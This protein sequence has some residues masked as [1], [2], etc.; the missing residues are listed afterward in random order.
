MQHTLAH[1]RDD[2]GLLKSK[3]YPTCFTKGHTSAD[4]V[5]LKTVATDEQ[6]ILAIK[7][8]KINKKGKKQQRVLVLTNLAVY[9]FK[10][11]LLGSID[12]K[13]YKRRIELMSIESI[14][15]NTSNMNE[16]I[17]K[18]PAEYDYRYESTEVEVIIMS[19]QHAWNELRVGLCSAALSVPMQNKLQVFSLDD[20]HITALLSTKSVSGGGSGSF[21]SNKQRTQPSDSLSSLSSS[22][23]SASVD[24]HK[25]SLASRSRKIID[26]AGPTSGGSTKSER[27][28]RRS[29]V[30]DFITNNNNNNTNTNNIDREH[31]TGRL[32]AA[33]SLRNV[34]ERSRGMSRQ[35]TKSRRMSMRD[36]LLDN[37]VKRIDSGSSSSTNSIHSSSSPRPLNIEGKNIQQHTLTEGSS[38]EERLDSLESL[39]SMFV[40]ER[41]SSTTYNGTV[42]WTPRKRPTS[43]LRDNTQE[44]KTYQEVSNQTKTTARRKSRKAPAVPSMPAMPAMPAM[45]PG[46]GR[47]KS[48]KGIGTGLPPSIAPPT[49]SGTTRP[50]P[51]P[52]TSSSSSSSSSST[53]TTTTSSTSP[54]RKKR[55][56]RSSIID[57]S[58][59]S[60]LNNEEVAK[61][62]LRQ[63]GVVALL[64]MIDAVSE[65]KSVGDDET[66]RSNLL[67]ELRNQEMHDVG[68]TS[69][70]VDTSVAVDATTGLR[71]PT[72]L[73]YL[74]I[75]RLTTT[76]L[77]HAEA[78]PMLIS[79]LK[80][81]VLLVEIFLDSVLSGI[82][83]PLERPR[84]WAIKALWKT[85][86]L[87][88]EAKLIHGAQDVSIEFN[89]GVTEGLAGLCKCFHQTDYQALLQ[90]LLNLI[91]IP[92]DTN[93]S[94]TVEPFGK[95]INA[96]K[97]LPL[98]F[99]LLLLSNNTM[100]KDVLKDVNYL[101]CTS[102]IQNVRAFVSQKNWQDWMLPLLH[103]IPYWDG[104]N[105][106]VKD[107]VKDRAH[108]VHRRATKKEV[109]P[110][111]Q[112]HL[113]SKKTAPAPKNSLP[114]APSSKKN[115]KN[116]QARSSNK[117]NAL[118]GFVKKDL[119]GPDDV[120]KELRALLL[121]VYAMV[122]VFA[123]R[124]SDYSID[125]VLNTG[126][127]R[128][129]RFVGAALTHDVVC[130]TRSILIGLIHKVKTKKNIIR[131]RDDFDSDEWDALFRL[132][133]VV[134]DFLFKK[135]IPRRV[136]L[137]DEHD[138]VNHCTPVELF[139]DRCIEIVI[140]NDPEEEEQNVA[141][142]VKQCPIGGRSMLR[143]L[144]PEVRKEVKREINS[145]N[146]NTISA[147]FLHLNPQTMHCLDLQLVNAVCDMM[148][149]VGYKETTK[150]G[151]RFSIQMQQQ[152]GCTPLF[153][154]SST[155]AYKVE[156]TLTSNDVS[157]MKRSSLDRRT[158]G[159]DIL[160]DFR[161]IQYM[162]RTINSSGDKQHTN[163][164]HDNDDT[165][166][167]EGSGSNTTDVVDIAALFEAYMTKAKKRSKTGLISNA[168]SK[169][170]VV[171]EFRGALTHLKA[172]KMIR[173]QSSLHVEKTEA[174][175]MTRAQKEAIKSAS[176]ISL[177]PAILQI[178]WGGKRREESGGSTS[179]P[180]D[181]VATVEGD[182]EIHR[183]SIQARGSILDELLGLDGMLSI[184]GEH[185]CHKCGL[186]MSGDK[187][188]YAASKYWCLEN[189]QCFQCVK[190]SRVPPYLRYFE[191]DEDIYCSDCYLD[192]SFGANLCG[193]CF[194]PI[195][196]DDEDVRTEG[197]SLM[198]R[199]YHRDCLQCTSCS[200]HLLHGR[201]AGEMVHSVKKKPF[202]G[203]CY[204]EKYRTCPKCHLDPGP[205]ALF[206]CDKNWHPKCFS[207]AECNMTF[208]ALG[209]FFSKDALDGRG[210]LPYCAQHFSQKFS[211]K[212]TS[213][214]QPINSIDEGANSSNGSSATTSP[215]KE[216]GSRFINA[217]S[218]P[219]HIECFQCTVCREQLEG[220][221]F[222]EGG[223]FYCEH[224][225][226]E[227]FG[228]TCFGCQETIRDNCLQASEHTWHIQCFKC[229]SC[230]EQ[231]DPSV[232]F[233]HGQRIFCEACFCKSG[234]AEMC[235][236]CG[237][238]II[239]GGVQIIR[240][241]ETV[242]WHPECA[243]CAQ[244]ERFLTATTAPDLFKVDENK[245]L[246]CTQHWQNKFLDCCD[247]CNLRIEG[248]E[249]LEYPIKD[250][251]GEDKNVRYHY[252][253]VQ[254]VGCDLFLKDRLDAGDYHAQVDQM[255][256]PKDTA[257][258]NTVGT[259]CHDCHWLL[260]CDS[261]S[262]CA[263]YIL[264]GQPKKQ[265]QNGTTWHEGCFAC[266]FCEQ[267]ITGSIHPWKGQEN[268]YCCKEHFIEEFLT[269][270]IVCDEPILDR[271][272]PI[273]GQS[274]H[275]KCI[276]CV[277]CGAAGIDPATQQVMGRKI[278]DPEPEQEPEQELAESNKGSTT[279]ANVES[280]LVCKDHQTPVSLTAEC[281]SKVHQRY[282]CVAR[283]LK[284]TLERKTKHAQLLETT[285]NALNASVQKLAKKA[286]DKQ[287]K[288]MHVEAFYLR[289]AKRVKDEV[290]TQSLVEEEEEV[291]V[292]EEEEVKV[293]EENLPEG[294][295]ICL[296]DGGNTYYHQQL[297]GH[298]QW[299]F[300]GKN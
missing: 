231:L 172:R 76:I 113:S 60:P 201:G 217:N 44:T 156:H 252:E 174:M 52:P 8:I 297:S 213:C 10:Y 275:M 197:V 115:H 23:S 238:H 66:C 134:K 101:L 133:R 93:P 47:R 117:W 193:T 183:N 171:R 289:G 285:G 233:A 198:G 14:H 127:E 232:Y 141:I 184:V 254:C 215:E 244:C 106:T 292:K 81:N 74:K 51:P 29:S 154:G 32:R 210:E 224:D 258:S 105:K 266:I 107:R 268:M 293:E 83:C 53:S 58:P 206:Y 247:A 2:V 45:P 300:P 4:V 187:L 200:N 212:C 80:E 163:I 59:A 131:W 263:E 71:H 255:F 246:Y 9:N 88:R 160:R 18:V 234:H 295:E 230:N 240:S 150:G 158:L 33:S 185:D 209:E 286:T 5:Y 48:T 85:L 162:F 283:D 167:C 91:V 155:K 164:A 16:F 62:L 130:V 135:R 182:T 28:K 146:A 143:P 126:I 142:K 1:P 102:H 298:T 3:Y 55:R 67:M 116:K 144:R 264:D 54:S 63:V 112:R 50:L 89:V 176:S 137:D 253:C 77:Y 179:P 64:Q 208:D 249:F 145:M 159:A 17:L 38:R 190:C 291:K 218:M 140:E 132:V 118:K 192:S 214:A 15:S 188:I 147:I 223:Q 97:I 296:D 86:S 189:L 205:D 82:S 34:L 239:E 277:E 149:V 41:S 70:L 68:R 24:G 204:Q 20:N 186:R 30:S 207:C 226:F 37:T 94:K 237:K 125:R 243:S 161:D 49:S 27:R 194:K 46:M 56:R 100:R 165:T 220:E 40:H 148:N 225:Y 168:F 170:Q 260:H 251:N 290:V 92:T 294:W 280:F 219:F 202:C 151:G 178:G 129:K 287:K 228:E 11:S 139:G 123:F 180:S 136:D 6:L 69:D 267:P 87:Y 272:I 111:P 124:H 271:A 96:P 203:A 65:V 229:Y 152:M 259:Y 196:L 177:P 241:D 166:G 269:S 7:L 22:S 262:W 79:V 276:L 270:C 175:A 120:Q 157:S 169:K 104:G 279:V 248:V 181:T 221:F 25:N 26:G 21:R 72:S 274:Y 108:Q 191:Q 122:H 121:N 19:L 199:I 273:F 288:K 257:G 138:Y 278:S 39:L 103:R 227:A 216:R 282:V 119:N 173:A 57:T 13:N 265:L 110:A 153:G 109:L 245:V 211:V 43:T 95:K 36:V 61:R 98:I 75:L 114:S 284:K 261:C 78:G 31:N 42:E 35:N 99:D 222:S 236:C 195:S 299:D 12:F 250:T 256:D 235:A 128:M 242:S 84:H 73:G 281:L 90:I